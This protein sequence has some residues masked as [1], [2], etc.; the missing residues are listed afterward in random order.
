VRVDN[1]LDEGRPGETVPLTILPHREH[2][3]ISRTYS[4][5]SNVFELLLPIHEVSALGVVQDR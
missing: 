2:E 1:G 3:R 5:S 4:E